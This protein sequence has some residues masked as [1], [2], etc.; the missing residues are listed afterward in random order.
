MK[1]LATSCPLLNV[2]ALEAQHNSLFL[3][4][5]EINTSA[6]GEQVA[7]YSVTEEPG[8]FHLALHNKLADGKRDCGKDMLPA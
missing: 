6:P 4:S 3:V 8:T 1:D 2:K 5:A 7:F